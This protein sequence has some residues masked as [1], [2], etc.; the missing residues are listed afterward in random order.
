MTFAAFK[1]TITELK[2]SDSRV[3]IEIGFP[4]NVNR[5]RYQNSAKVKAVDLLL[6]LYERFLASILSK[7]ADFGGIPLL[8][9]HNRNL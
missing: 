3:D 1:V 9:I 4:H 6:S 5:A 2:V 8:H 7:I